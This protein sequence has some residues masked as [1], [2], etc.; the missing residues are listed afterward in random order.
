MILILPPLKLNEKL[1][2]VV[3]DRTGAIYE[4][5]ESC[6]PLMVLIMADATATGRYRAVVPVSTIADLVSL[7]VPSMLV[8]GR[9]SPPR[10]YL[11]VGRSTASKK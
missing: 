3:K 5:S 11:Y 8:H 6:C 4:P 10:Q 2:A 9:L 1:V 7:Q